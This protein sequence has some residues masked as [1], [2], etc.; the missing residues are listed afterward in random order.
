M[1]KIYSLASCDTC[2]K[3]L[4]EVAPGKD[5]EI[6]NIKECNI[7]PKDLDRAAQ[8]LGSY[9][10]LFS[11]KAVKYRSLGLHLKTL[12]EKDIR[13]LILSE[14]TFLKRPVA[15]ID[16]KVTAGH[17]KEAIEDLKLSLK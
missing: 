7:S 4:K 11:R 12:A 6:I 14:Y 16:N 10:A 3:I 5:V 15:I 13:K 17:T 1:K 2:R 9:E 8:L